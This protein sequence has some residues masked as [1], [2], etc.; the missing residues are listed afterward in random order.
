MFRLHG[1]GRDQAR[2]HRRRAVSGTP[3]LPVPRPII[4]H[5]ISRLPTLDLQVQEADGLQEE[6]AAAADEE[7]AVPAPPPD[8]AH[9]Q[10]RT[11]R[12]HLS[13]SSSTRSPAHPIPSSAPPP[14][15]APAS[16]TLT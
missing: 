8:A 11:L 6:E 10:L 4:T 9:G 3:P 16:V 7:A 13:A 2:A 14:P 12:L 15:R 5:P 1:N